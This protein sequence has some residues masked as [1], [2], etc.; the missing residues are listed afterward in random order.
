MIERGKLFISH[1]GKTIHRPACQI[2]EFAV[3]EVRLQ[4]KVIS[5]CN[6]ESR[7]WLSMVNLNTLNSW[8]SSSRTDKIV[9]I[10]SAAAVDSKF[11][12]AKIVEQLTAISINKE[13]SL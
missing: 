10:G 2:V 12:W 3:Y 5:N 11:D 13:S 6:P 9:Y 7:W 1:R 8:N 4:D